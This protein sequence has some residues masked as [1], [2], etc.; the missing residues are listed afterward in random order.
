[1]N[2]TAIR[3]YLGQEK[4]FVDRAKSAADLGQVDL[5]AELLAQA[6]RNKEGVYEELMEI[7][8]DERGLGMMTLRV[9]KNCQE[10]R[11]HPFAIETQKIYAEGEVYCAQKLARR[12]N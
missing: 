3:N 4:D 5:V 6:R 7:E 8:A 1:M 9:L 12:L 11:T 2:E 10:R